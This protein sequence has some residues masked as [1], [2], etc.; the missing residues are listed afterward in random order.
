MSFDVICRHLESFADA[1]L[2]T[3]CSLHPL[4][5][6]EL[7]SELSETIALSTRVT[8]KRRINVAVEFCS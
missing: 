7:I 6:C 3:F 2:I 8:Q 1:G 5:V 4:D